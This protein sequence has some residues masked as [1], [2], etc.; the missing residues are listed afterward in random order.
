MAA[1]AS[2]GRAAIAWALGSVRS[3]LRT[4][5]WLLLAVMGAFSENSQR[6][7]G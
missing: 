5:A 6:N 1:L 7:S 2:G 3:G 4:M